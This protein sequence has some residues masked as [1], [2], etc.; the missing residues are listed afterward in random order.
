M[1]TITR[2]SRLSPIGAALVSLGV[3]F[4]FSATTTGCDKINELTGKGSSGETKKKKKKKKDSDESESESEAETEASA[5]PSASASASAAPT[6]TETADA[7]TPPA[8]DAGTPEPTVKDEVTHYPDEIPQGGTVRL[9]VVKKVYQAADIMSKELG[10]LAPGTFINLKTS[11][12][13]WMLIEWPSG[14]GELS[15][16]WIQ[17]KRYD[18]A[19]A[20]EAT[21]PPDS[22]LI[23]P[24]ATTPDAAVPD[25]AVP[26]AAVPDAGT[27]PDAAT[28]AD[29]G[30]ARPK[31]DGGFKIP[32][33]L[34]K[35]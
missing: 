19:A 2:G 8:E 3:L 1:K 18:K 29:A 9:K 10:S 7:G 20:E 5:E 6:A 12:A 24:D 35:K 15:L 33:K 27:K 30:T 28:P 25:A 31:L 21:P 13:E 23:H 14:V 17:L 4:A 26:D 32:I 34:P 22:G 16:G 11:H